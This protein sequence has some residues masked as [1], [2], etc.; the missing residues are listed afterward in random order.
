MIGRAGHH[1][2]RLALV[3][4][5]SVADTWTDRLPNNGQPKAYIIRSRLDLYLLGANTLKLSTDCFNVC[6]QG[7]T[8]EFEA[9]D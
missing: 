1:G 6:E 5:L 2:L 9:G 7:V 4:T 3:D 8:R